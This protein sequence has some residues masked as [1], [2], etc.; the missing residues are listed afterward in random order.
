MTIKTGNNMGDEMDVVEASI[1]N[2]LELCC[3]QLA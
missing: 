2:K 1:I 3:A